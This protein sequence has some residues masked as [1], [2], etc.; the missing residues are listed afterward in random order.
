MLKRVGITLMFLTAVTFAQDAAKCKTLSAGDQNWKNNIDW[1]IGNSD[2]GGSVDCP[3][4]YIYPEC[5]VAGGRSCI[6]RKGIQSAK[7]GDYAN[8]FLQAKVC[9]CHNTN[10]RDGIMYCG[11]KQAVGDYLKTK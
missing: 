1:C 3:Q 9:Q 6:M 11:G 2:A 8:A 10:A 4:Q 5:I 7:D